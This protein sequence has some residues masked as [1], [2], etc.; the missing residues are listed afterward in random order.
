MPASPRV[1]AQTTR[2]VGNPE[3]GSYLTA[4]KVVAGASTLSAAVE[5]GNFLEGLSEEDKKEV[6]AVLAALPAGV[7]RAFMASLHAALNEGK[8][9]EFKWEELR[10]LRF[11][12][13]VMTTGDT[14]VLTLRTPHP[15]K[16]AQP[17]S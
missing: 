7:D 17:S 13:A 9:I 3:S 11:E 10:E 2:A 5:T 16:L 6:R 15:S 4:Q 12:H 8:R 1:A 14:A